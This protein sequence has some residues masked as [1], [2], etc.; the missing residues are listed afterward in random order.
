MAKII[1]EK[2]NNYYTKEIRLVKDPEKMKGLLNETRWEILKLIAER[3][4]YPAEISKKLKIHEQKVY[5]HIKQLQKN[6]LIKIKEKEERG[7]ALA[8][9]FTVQDYAFALEL[10]YGDEKILDFPVQKK[11]SNLNNFLNPFLQ[12]GK[13]NGKIIVGSPD[14]HGNH[15]VRARDGHYATDLA[16]FLG[17]HAS[18]PEDFSVRLDVDIKAERGY[19]DNLFLVGGV[20]TNVIT[21]EMNSYLPVKFDLKNFPF[22]NIISERTG[23]NYTEDTC[24]IIA[25]ITNPKN[26]KKSVFIIA[27]NRYVGTKSAVLAFTRYTDE[28]LENYE[29]EDNWARVIVGKD[30]KGDGK[31]D[32][33]EILE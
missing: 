11:V 23:E 33:I 7:G 4:M 26:M 27:G 18:L 17:Q 13:I 21:T 24:G 32:D 28:V 3:P 2:N 1:K 14:P 10:P 31:V 9:Y 20:L 15:Q 22:R 25:K 5:Y 19:D 8:K 6:G 29:G 30:M 16:L 12:N